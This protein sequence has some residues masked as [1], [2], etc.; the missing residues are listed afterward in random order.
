MFHVKHQEGE[1]PTEGWEAG[2]TD[3]SH[4]F[5]EAACRL[6]ETQYGQLKDYCSY[7]YYSSG[8]INLI[9]EGDRANLATKHVLPS[10][11][12]AGLVAVVPNAAVLDLGSGAGL[13]GIPLKV[14]FPDSHFYLVE[15]RRRRAN[16]LREVTRK[17]DL[18]RIEI[19]NERVEALHPRLAQTI[20]VV[21]SRATKNLTA[22]LGWVEPIL[23][24]HGVLIVTLDQER[25]LRKARGIIVRRK[26]QWQGV[27][28][29]SGVVR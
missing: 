25:G 22:L 15:S 18:K 24:P 9:A 6:T 21:V 8:K 11:C 27:V 7:L 12:L 28:S 16:F 29:W 5:D 1:A 2:F 26:S 20:D 13:P 14:L 17:L 10:L 19:C 23:K 4:W 3:L